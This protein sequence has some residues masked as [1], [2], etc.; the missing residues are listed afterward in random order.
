M[1]SAINHPCPGK[2]PNIPKHWATFV[3]KINVLSLHR[4]GL[5]VY[6]D[7][8]LYLLIDSKHLPYPFSQ[9]QPSSSS[10]RHFTSMLCPL[11]KAS[12]APA[13]TSLPRYFAL[14]RTLPFADSSVARVL[15][16]T[17]RASVSIA[18][19][20]PSAL[21]EHQDRCGTSQQQK[22]VC[23]GRTCGAE[24]LEQSGIGRKR[25]CDEQV[26]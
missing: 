15:A 18:G 22:N 10:R 4:M 12:A 20:N 19:L 5:E 9:I 2:P 14:S 1:T 21:R 25:G 11:A 6:L 3:A 17:V 24:R 8:S 7:G 23:G 26:E 13:L 16:R